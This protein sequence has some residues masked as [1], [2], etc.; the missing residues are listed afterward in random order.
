VTLFE[1]LML[2]A[3]A[4]G[5]A[6]A[7]AGVAAEP[8]EEPRPGRG[9]LDVP[10]WLASAEILG[11]RVVRVEA[12]P[13]RDV[14]EAEPAAAPEEPALPAPEPRARPAEPRRRGWRPERRPATAGRRRL[15]PPRSEEQPPRP[16]VEPVTEER[17]CR[18]CGRPISAERLRAI[19]TATECIDCRRASVPE[20]VEPAGPAETE[21]VAAEEVPAAAVDRPP[22]ALSPSPLADAREWNVWELERLARRVG[23]KAVAEDDERSFLLVYLREFATPE[24]L[25]PADFDALVRE[26]F[27][28][29]VAA[30]DN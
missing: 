27:P 3:Q 6:L 28:E 21:P 19:P 22:P 11:V 4:R 23:G 5:V 9:S 17:L 15:A 30:A 20:S 24:G 14:A 7:P 2:R 25:L 1:R 12:A 8:G 29:L 16:D 10:E 13:A 18:T 26:S